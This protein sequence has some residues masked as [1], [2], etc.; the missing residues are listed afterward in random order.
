MGTNSSLHSKMSIEYEDVE[1]PK[2]HGN[3]VTTSW[4]RAGMD[5]RKTARWLK[6][7]WE[8]ANVQHEPAPLLLKSVVFIGNTVDSKATC[9]LSIP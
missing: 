9:L 5:S 2:R 8:S 1:N 3:R 6:R 7:N 4:G